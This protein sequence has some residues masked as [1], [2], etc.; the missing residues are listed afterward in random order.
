MKYITSLLLILTTIAAMPQ[1]KSNDITG[2]WI[3]EEGTAHFEIY[4]TG[5]Y[6]SAKIIWLSNPQN[7]K[8]EAKIDKNN[9]DKSLRTRP[10]LNMTILT[11]LTFSPEKS[12]WVNG[13]IYSPEK[14]MYADCKVSMSAVNELK[15]TASKHLFT[16]TK[17]WKRYE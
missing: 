4:Q 2:K 12:C 13:T 11:G 5:D 3:N 10:V 15:I 17:N 6:Y 16:S 14:G 1:T 9:P 8:G 7:D